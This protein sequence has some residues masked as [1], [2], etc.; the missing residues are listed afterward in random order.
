MR[1]TVLCRAVRRRHYVSL[2]ENEL[3][4][5]RWKPVRG[6]LVCAWSLLALLKA[7]LS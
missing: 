2:T 6:P 3:E 4:P 1:V 5:V 7:Q